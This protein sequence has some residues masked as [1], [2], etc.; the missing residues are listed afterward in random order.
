MASTIVSTRN[1]AIEGVAPSWQR[2]FNGAQAKVPEGTIIVSADNHWSLAEDPWKARAP[3][4]M[5]DRLPHVWWDEALGVNNIGFNGV[6]VYNELRAQGIKSIEARP[7]THRIKER[8]ADLDADGVAMEIVFPQLL[9]MFNAH[10]DI[11][12]RELIFRTY[13][14]YLADLQKE[15]GGRY[16]GVGF[17]NFWDP[18]KTRES[19][20]HIKDLGL[21]SFVTPLSPGVF[22]DSGAPIWYASQEMDVLWSAAEECNLPVWFHAGESLP[23]GN[24]G[25]AGALMLGIFMPF[26]K[27]WG[28]LVFGGV[29]DR[30]PNLRVAFAEAG[31]NWVP[32]MLQD[33]E[34]I[35][36]TIGANLMPGIKHRPSDYWHQNCYSTFMA[37]NVGLEMLKYIGSDRVMWAT[38]Y[39][40]SEGVHGYSKAIIEDVVARVSP[41]EAKRIL[42]GTAIELFDLV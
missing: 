3:A 35:V 31:I 16:F 22:P 6:G 9:L 25:G 28:E 37:D 11:E 5:Q 4:S 1:M 26:R 39:P 32:G 34:M 13:N 20:H 33:A 10:P 17:P 19:I 41:A 8:M 7:G 30:H 12:A 23:V 36:D 38:D 18:S 14:E 15:S 40:H 29:F 42:G 2:Q 24:P 27:Q 21:K